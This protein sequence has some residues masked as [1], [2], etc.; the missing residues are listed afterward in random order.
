[1]R[2]PLIV[3]WPGRVARGGVCPQPVALLDLPPTFFAIAGAPLPWAMHGH[4]LQPLLKN[5]QADWDHPVLLENFRWDFGSD[6]D[7]GV[8]GDQMHSGVPWW[9]AF[10]KG[11]HKYIRTLVPNE[12]EELYDLSS[13]PDELK[14]L[15]LDPGNQAL[16]TDYRERMTAEL[17]RTKAG[18]ARNLPA[19][20]LRE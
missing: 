7:R 4:D 8:T 16:L 10:W 9:L 11:H 20:R 1:M 3:R 17:T 2:M 5:P 18:L 12:I 6:T 15:A 19:P 14:N 13:D